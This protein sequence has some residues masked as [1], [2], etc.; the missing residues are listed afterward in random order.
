MSNSEDI[1]KYLTERGLVQAMILVL[2]GSHDGSHEHAAHCLT[3]V[4]K[5]NSDAIAILRQKEFD[6][7]SLLEKKIAWIK[8]S[9]DPEVHQELA[10][11]CN[12]LL[13]MVNN[14]SSDAD[15]SGNLEPNR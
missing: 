9:E 4:C 15:G 6:F 10:A 5:D 2:H 12:E 13:A 1:K 3:C 7:A 8:G 14:G 11:F